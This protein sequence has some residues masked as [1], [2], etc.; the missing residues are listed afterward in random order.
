MINYKI[1]IWGLCDE[2]RDFRD[3][4]KYRYATKKNL[5]LFK[6]NRCD[7]PFIIALML[8]MMMLMILMIMVIVVAVELV[9]TVEVALKEEHPYFH[10]QL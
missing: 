9:V 6:S 2:E 10:E 8:T 1:W 4:K 7:F 3:K 5:F